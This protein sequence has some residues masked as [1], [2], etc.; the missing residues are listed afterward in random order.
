MP[1]ITLNKKAFSALVGKSVPLETL[2]DRISYL[3]TD[4]EKIDDSEIVVEVFPNRPDMLSTPGLARALS[5]FI[6]VKKGL[7]KYGVAAS[8]EEV[9]IDKSVSKVRPYT[10]CAIVRGLKFDD[11]K[12]REVIDIQEKLHVTYGRNRKK[13]A[14]GIYPYEKI[15]PPIRFVAKKPEEIRFRPLEF[16][17]EI[18]GLQIL[19]QH[20]TG[21]EYS[22]LL[23]G[24]DLFPVFIDSNNKIL[25]MPPIINSHDT[26]KITSETKDVFIECSGFDFEVLHKCINIIAA[27]LSDLGGKIYSMKLRYPDKTLTTPSLEPERMKVDIGYINKKL[28]L[29]LK[30]AQVKSLLEKMGHGYAKGTALIPAYRADILHQI[31]LA[32]EIAIAYGYENFEAA[33]PNAATIAEEDRADV[34]KRRLSELLV[35]LGFLEINTYNL[36][37]KL[38]QSEKMA[39]KTDVVELLNSV[40]KEHN[41]LRA[42]LIP[43]IMET[44]ASNKHQEYP[45]KIFGT[46]TVFRK[47]ENAETGISEEERLAIAVSH[48]KANFTEI[49]QI[50]NYLMASLG[51]KCEISEAEHPSFIAGRAA[52]VTV[53]GKNVATFGELSPE[54]LANWQLEMPVA[55]ME[56]NLDT[57]FNLIG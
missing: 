45:Q 33:I 20:P 13:V 37:N 40:S 1:T 50:L 17:R 32:E 29:S 5:S 12:I 36:T 3:G 55:A 49:K 19:S 52:S 21:R 6:G 14:I 57:L 7:R 23:E 56:I 47:D 39:C 9:V 4:L 2:K 24:K 28:G 16:P 53:K 11:E 25:S 43:N 44:F 30:E 35:G 46:G 38:A 42:W 26:G 48:A 34:F 18:S 15:K 22:H 41:V 51:L 10:A 8:G 27:A 31:D 54:V